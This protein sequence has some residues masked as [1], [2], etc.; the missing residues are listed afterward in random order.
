[1]KNLASLHLGGKI[2]TIWVIFVATSRTAF[3]FKWWSPLNQSTHS[4][5]KLKIKKEN[6][7]EKK[8]RKDPVY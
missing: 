1:M 3:T 2:I 6:K 4:E 5:K 7:E 8:E